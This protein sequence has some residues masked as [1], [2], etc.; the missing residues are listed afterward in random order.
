[1][2]QI[3]SG[4]GGGE[5]LTI[6]AVSFAARA[7]LYD[8]GGAAVIQNNYSLVNTRES[9]LVMMG[10]NDKTAV[11]MRVDDSG[12][13]ATSKWVPLIW[14]NWESATLNLQRWDTT[15]TTF[16]SAFSVSGANLN[17][18]NLLTA[19]AVNNLRTTKRVPYSPR[20]PIVMKWRGKFG[21][22]PFCSVSVGLAD[23]ISGVANPANAVAM[24]F[25]TTNTPIL[26]I[27]QNSAV[28]G[29]VTP[30]YTG[31]NTYD[32]NKYYSYTIILENDQISLLIE[33]TSIGLIIARAVYGLGTGIQKLHFTTHLQGY[34]RIYNAVSGPS[35]FGI[36]ILGQLTIGV[37]DTDCSRGVETVMAGNHQHSNNAPAT[38]VQNCNYTNSTEATTTALS[39]TA[40]SFAVLGG[41]FQFA[42]VAGAVTDYVLFGFTVPTGFTLV[43]NGIAIDT[44]NFGAAG[45]TTPTLLTWSAGANS[46]A[47][48]AATAVASGYRVH[49]LGSQSLP[50]GIAI[51]ANAT[52]VIRNFATPLITEAGRFF[53][54]LLRIP[55]GTATASQVIAGNVHIDG[56]LE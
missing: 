23:V 18:T 32:Q 55:V 40:A 56:Y 10:Q 6:D 36:C 15:A 48:S 8:T 45:A 39:N 12:G 42:A 54:I 2:P 46:T 19:S 34:T 3:N 1:M 4:A 11:S 50:I 5:A 20:A 37:L 30:T 47:V 49:H 51:G 53:A 28:V 26:N 22:Q 44:W 35:L 29:Q 7:T 25:T 21:G 9:G 17:S 52:P 27:Y 33:D 43:V 14:E 41:K 38:S 13:L 31:S 16:V 24:E